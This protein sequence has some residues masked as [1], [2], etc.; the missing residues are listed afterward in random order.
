[1]KD[2]PHIRFIKDKEFLL[3]KIKGNTVLYDFDLILE[4]ISSKGKELFGTSFKIHSEDLEIIYKLCV[5]FIKEKSAC[6]KHNLDL[7]KG[8][9]LTGP[10]GCG[11]TSLMKLFRF[12]IPSDKKFKVVACRNTVFGFNHLGYKVV[13]DYGNSDYYCFDDL[14]IEPEGKHFGSDCNVMGEIILSRYELFMLNNSIKQVTHITSNLNS[15]EIEQRYGN[16]VRSRMRQM[17]NLIAFSEGSLD[18]RN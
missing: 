2:Q 8:I 18:K 1:M 3:G 11:K 13:E 10:V 15:N 16:R 6:K 7:E 5:Y 9:L 4:Y 17:F 12:L 14:G